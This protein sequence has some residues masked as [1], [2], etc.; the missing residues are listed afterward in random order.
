[1]P[2]IG[3]IHTHQPATQRLRQL[4]DLVEL[5]AE[6]GGVEILTDCSGMKF[7]ECPEG[8]NSSYVGTSLQKAGKWV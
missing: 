4:S 7:S 8:M 1:M 3:P 6:P 2:H 5:G